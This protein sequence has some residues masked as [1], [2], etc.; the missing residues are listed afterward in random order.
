MIDQSD[1]WTEQDQ[2]DLLSFSSQYA[3]TSLYETE[4]VDYEG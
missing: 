4:D 1:T 2:F 3:V